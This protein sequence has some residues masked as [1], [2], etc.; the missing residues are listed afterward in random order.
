MTE[1]IGIRFKEIG[2]VYYFAPGNIKVAQGDRV[3]VE[4]ARGVECGEVVIPN[5]MV[6]DGTAETHNPQG[7]RRRL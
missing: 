4:T 5:R 2:K 7:Y 1:I 6:D 3:I